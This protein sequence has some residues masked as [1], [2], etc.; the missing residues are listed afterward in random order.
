M[1]DSTTSPSPNAEAIG[2][3]QQLAMRVAALRAEL[4]GTTQRRRMARLGYE[5][6]AL[7]EGS[8]DQRSAAAKAYLDAFNNDPAYAPPLHALIRMFERRRSL[9]N[10]RQ[11]YDTQVGN[12]RDAAERA[13]ALTDRA[14]FAED[15]DAQDGLATFRAAMEADDQ[16]YVASLMAEATARRSGDLEASRAALDHRARSAANPIL[17]STLLAE[18]GAEAERAGDLEGAFDA[19][20]RASAIAPRPHALRLLARLARRHHRWTELAVALEELADSI[21][22]ESSLAREAAADEAAEH[23]EESRAR[24]EEV[25]F[26]LYEAGLVRLD[27]LDDPAA[28]STLLLQALRQGSG[29]QPVDPFLVLELLRALQQAGDPERTVDVLGDVLAR[30]LEPSLA[31]SVALQRA[32]AALARGDITLGYESLKNAIELEPSSSV[33]TAVLEGLLAKGRQH[34]ERVDLLV[35][36]AASSTGGARTQALWRAAGLTSERLDDFETARSLYGEALGSG[37]HRVALLR[38]MVDAALSHGRREVANELAEQLLGLELESDEHAAISHELL[39]ATLRF[40]SDPKEHLEALHAALADPKA[41]SYAPDIARVLA[42]GLGDFA[43]LARAHEALAERS[44]EDENAAAHFCAAARAFCRLAGPD[45]LERAAALLRRALE[46]A[47]ANPYALALL[48]EV[49][50]TRGET[51]E[52]IALLQQSAQGAVDAREAENA[53]LVAGAMAEL[54]ED[55]AGAAR[56]YRQAQ[57]LSPASEAPLRMMQRLARRTSDATL[58]R[59]ALEGLQRIERQRGGPGRASIELYEHLHLEAGDVDA[60]RD[61]LDDESSTPET[62]AEIAAHLLTLRADRIAGVV[63][64]R[65]A[66]SLARQAEGAD[67]ALLLREAGG[68]AALHEESVEG[69]L[70]A[71]R[72]NPSLATAMQIVHGAENLGASHEERA[73]AW[74]ELGERTSDTAAASELLLHGLRAATAEAGSEASEDLFLVAQELMDVAGESPEAAVAIDE[75]MHAGDDPDMRAEALLK[76]LERCTPRSSGSLRAATARALASSGR[77]A[78]ALRM[79]Q[80]LTVEDANDLASF[81]T[82]R[83]V[84]RQ[85]G[86]WEDVVRACDRLAASLDGAF[87]AR[88]LE[89]AGAVLMDHLGEDGEA[90]LRLREALELDVTSEIAFTRLRDL[91]LERE[92]A[93]EL[94][95]L[96]DRRLDV[97]DAEDGAERVALLYERARLFRAEGKIGQA[98]D[99]LCSLL[100]DEPLHPGALALKAE[101]HVS[102]QAWDQAVVALQSLGDADVPDSQKRVALLGAAEFLETKLEDP[103]AALQLLKR[104]VELDPSDRSLDLKIANIAGRAGL[105]GDVVDALERAMENEDGHPLV[106]LAQR[107]AQ[108]RAQRLGDTAGAIADHRRAMHAEPTNLTSLDALMKLLGKGLERKELAASFEEAVRFELQREGPTGTVLRKLYRAAEL[109]DKRTLASLVLGAAEA[110]DVG[111]SG[112]IPIGS[113]MKAEQSRPSGAGLS[114][115]A[116]EALRL[117]TTGGPHGELAALLEPTLI[118]ALSLEPKALG[119]VKGDLISPRGDNPI[120]D[121][122][123]LLSSAFGLELGDFYVDGRNASRIVGLPGK[124]G[125]TNWIVGTQVVAPFNGRQRFEVGRLAMGVRMGVLPLILR[126]SEEAAEILHAAYEA[127][128]VELAGRTN[129]ARPELVA[130]IGHTMPRKVKK[131]VVDIAGRL[132]DGGAELTTY[133][134]GVHQTTRRA[135]LLLSG[136]LSVALRYVLR[137]DPTPDNTR[138]SRT[139]WDLIT[140]WLSPTFASLQ[141]S[142]GLSP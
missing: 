86:A 120:R 75:T 133:C 8:L 9:E 22:D 88:V 94:L 87:R 69:L 30:P 41:R 18:C 129:P 110:F 92:A 46:H 60:V 136:D 124:K 19:L 55:F 6:G 57:E 34:R 90:E 76:R 44:L 130:R 127:A 64:A 142:L 74:L 7:L 32:E 83:Q 25:A 56:S 33:A 59:T 107:S 109:Q 116:I 14:A 12:A 4:E 84:A 68:R 141:H 26:L 80:Q 132:P 43:L 85:V 20:H 105:Y 66:L 99:S 89:E 103:A 62:Y 77:L 102:E 31:A 58:A 140:F 1:N 137:S 121:D 39:S 106:E 29:D 65:A 3:P 111:W 96:V 17:Q 79:L 118:E 40:S 81:D 91:L 131:A 11:L 139:A 35:A 71:L 138:K 42:P 15:V 134:R 72:A 100:E 48:E 101:I 13:S 45:D 2:T 112:M 50:R 67:A 49:L 104:V 23:P 63:A 117:P 52:I 97:L 113:A 98:A 61:V 93:G 95:R 24:V 27:E 115:D 125:K 53:L 47:P 54:A 82:L 126:P 51:Q 128:G 119:V 38:E 108:I 135:G 36:S 78:D 70:S 73:N 37:E 28:A 122:L 16:S 5:L 10:L 123:A 114:P 21:Q